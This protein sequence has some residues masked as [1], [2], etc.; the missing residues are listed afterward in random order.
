MRRMLICVAAMG[1]VIAGCDR[2]DTG[3]TGGTVRVGTNANVDATGVDTERNLTS[4]ND[5]GPGRTDTSGAARTNVSGQSTDGAVRNGNDNSLRGDA[6]DADRR[7]DASARG[8]AEATETF[9]RE[10]ASANRMEVELGQLATRKAENARVKEFG[11]RMVDDH[12]NANQQLMTLAK[13]ESI[14]GR[15]GMIEK[16][17]QH[18]NHLS[19][20][21]GA[22]FDKA[23][24]RMMV[25]DHQ[26]D[27]LKF[28]AQ[29]RG[30]KDEDVRAFAQR[31]LP[32]LREHLR[33]AQDIQRELGAGTAAPAGGR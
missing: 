14:D 24:I 26:Q 18:V 15:A 31:I 3:R 5:I 28:E 22:E 10:A 7:G 1:F 6:R 4:G 32:I 9:L 23:Y 13:T 27:V 21:Q 25:E 29:A 11:Q 19:G 30:A 8:E 20:L 16:H 12:E 33:M 2:Y 17:Q